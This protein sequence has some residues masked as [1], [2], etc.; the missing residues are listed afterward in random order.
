MWNSFSCFIPS[1]LT[2]SQEICCGRRGN[3][4]HSGA[5]SMRIVIL[6]SSPNLRAVWEKLGFQAGRCT[7]AEW[8][9]H[10]YVI[11]CALSKLLSRST[12][13][14]SIEPVTGWLLDK[15][16]TDPLYRCGTGGNG[17]KQTGFDRFI[18]NGES[19]LRPL[20]T[21][22]WKEWNWE[23]RLGSANE[24]D[25]LYVESCVCYSTVNKWQFGRLSGR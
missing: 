8:R 22:A 1:Q 11:S 6:F 20:P 23:S 24:R 7:P 4:Q 14:V 10:K 9:W 2:C 25:H 17:S 15:R 3:R 16:R 13:Q 18:F 19:G 12:I 21:D 5:F